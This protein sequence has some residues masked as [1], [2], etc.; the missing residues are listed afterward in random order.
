M[1]EVANIYSVIVELFRAAH[2]PNL[3]RFPDYSSI[4]D[5]LTNYYGPKYKNI[6]FCLDDTRFFRAN[7]YGVDYWIGKTSKVI[8]PSY[9]IGMNHCIVFDGMIKCVVIDDTLNNSTIHD[10]IMIVE[11]LYETIIG[12]IDPT[13]S[14][15]YIPALYSAIWFMYDEYRINILDDE[16]FDI[17]IEYMLANTSLSFMKNDADIASIKRFIREDAKYCNLTGSRFPDLFKLSGIKNRF[18]LFISEE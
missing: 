13:D 5:Q 14:G 15:S 9:R 17:T 16:Y 2:T 1:N 11:T 18:K 8:H 10:S 4:K 12:L 3:I 7:F 6:D